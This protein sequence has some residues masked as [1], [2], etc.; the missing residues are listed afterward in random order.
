MKAQLPIIKGEKVADNAD[1]RDA[2]LVNYTAVYKPVRGSNGYILSHPGLTSLATGLGVDRGAIWNERQGEHFRISGTN[3]ITLSPTGTVTDIGTI[4]GSDQASLAYSFTTQSIVANG[5]WYLYD[6][7]DLTQIT[8]TAVGTPIDHTW[9][10][11]VYFFTDGENLYHT[12]TLDETEIAPLNFA[13]SEFSPDPTLAVDKTSENQVIVF[14]RYTTEWF[15]NVATDNFGWRR[16]KGKAVK[17]GIVGTH[18]ETE[19]VGVFYVIGGGKEESPS[20]HMISGG[21][22]KSIASREVD[23]VLAEYTE[24]ELSTAVLETRVQ[25]RD[26]FILVRLLRDT[27]IFNQTIAEKVGID[28]AWSILRT[29][30]GNGIWR[31]ANGVYD[32]RIPCWVY[33]DSTDSSIACLDNEVAT[34]YGEKVEGIF[35]T[36]LVNVDSASIDQFEVDILPGH[37]VN[38]ED[39][40]AAVSLTYNGV[41]YGKEWWALIGEKNVYDTRFIVRRLGY[42]RDYVGGKVRTVSAERLAFSMMVMDYG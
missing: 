1:Y 31:A 25:D 18:A 29:G 4:P 21:S 42:V 34:Q 30:T 36:P 37:Q 11:G 40:T 7:T 26:R 41:T 17:C 39:V 35:F 14:N 13:T 33:G 6:G 27:L 23:K 32:P 24:D 12:E 2:L 28:S 22:Y 9:I 5:R 16:I 20:V 10:D 38:L 19:M 8:G 15:E 3:L